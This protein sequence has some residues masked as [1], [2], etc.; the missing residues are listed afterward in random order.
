MSANPMTS[1]EL[2]SD[3]IKE[4]ENRWGP[5]VTSMAEDDLDLCLIEDEETRKTV[6]QKWQQLWTG[7]SNKNND[8]T[9]GTNT[10]ASA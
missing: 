10:F 1:E 2:I 6:I 7:G 5:M 3:L 9:T 8:K 4:E